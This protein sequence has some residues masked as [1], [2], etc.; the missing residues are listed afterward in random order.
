[1]PGKLPPIQFK[2]EVTPG[3][4][5][6][7]GDLI[8]GEL[9]VNIADAKLYV[10]DAGGNPILLSSGVTASVFFGPTAPPTPTVG[11]LWYDTTFG[12]LNIYDGA[13]WLP[14]S[15]AAAVSIVSP[16]APV[17]PILG[18]IWTEIPSNITYIW[19]GA[20]WNHAVPAVLRSPTTDSEST[21]TSQSAT[22]T[23]LTL[24]AATSQT[25]N[26]LEAQQSG[27]GQ[28]MTL[29]PSGLLWAVEIDCGTF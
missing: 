15:T 14:A 3:L 19:D 27:G 22:V 13:T 9:A 28:V 18:T 11:D 20:M 12:Q 7:V 10:G 5:P 2:R 8:E 29:D 17:S 4:L 6:V 26:I 25:A 24:R 23:T 21:V 16:T 1:M